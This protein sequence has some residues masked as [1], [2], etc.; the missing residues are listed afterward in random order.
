MPT[1]LE[2][3]MT[4][5][6]NVAANLAEITAQPKPTYAIDGQEVSWQSLF[7]SYVAQLQALN[8]QIA[9][10]DPFEGVS[11]GYSP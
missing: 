8:A 2:N 6:Q 5:R 7:E 4:A 9:A 1:L 3:L 10:A 11:Q